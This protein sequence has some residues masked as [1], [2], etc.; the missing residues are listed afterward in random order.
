MLSIVEF[1][2]KHKVPE[3]F[4]SNFYL[5]N[6]LDL[7]N[8]YQP[9]CSEKGI[10]ESQ[11][12]YYHYYNY[13]IKSFF[14]KS[15]ASREYLGQESHVN[16]NIILDIYKNT[17]I[18]FKV[19]YCLSTHNRLKFLKKTLPH[20]ISQLKNDEQIVL[21]DYGSSDGTESFIDNNFRIEISQEKLKFIQVF[22]VKY[23][24]ASIAKNISHYYSEG[25]YLYNIDCDNFI[26]NHRDFLN[27][28]I[29]ISPK[30]FVLH[31]SLQDLI[32]EKLG[33]E[34][35]FGQICMHRD[36][37]LALSGYNESFMP[38]GY[39]DTDILLRSRA[40]N[41]RYVNIPLKTEPVKHTKTIV[42]SSP[43]NFFSWGDCLDYNKKLS[44]Y[45][46]SK[47]S[48]YACNI[49]K[50]LR[51]RINFNEDILI[52]YSNT[53]DFTELFNITKQINPLGENKYD[54]LINHEFD[55]HFDLID[56]YLKN[57]SNELLY[58][59]PETIL[60][61][62]KKLKSNIINYSSKYC[63]IYSEFSLDK[64]YTRSSFTNEK[65]WLSK[66]IASENIIRQKTNGSSTGNSF[67]FFNNNRYFDKVQ[68]IFEFDLIRSEYNLL[69]KKIKLLLLINWPF[70]PDGF[71]GFS[72]C[73][74]NHQPGNK[75]NNFNAKNYTTHF[76]NFEGY[77]D[78]DVWYNKLLDL[79]SK[80]T[81]DIVLSS[82]PIIN[83][84][85]K[86][87]KQNSFRHK[88]AKLLSHT[89]EFPRHDDFNFL[90]KH[91]NID[92][93]CDHMRCWDG[94]ATFFTCKHGTYHLN[95][96]ASWCE[97][98]ENKE[99]ISTDYFNT[100]TPFLNYFN[101]DLC[102]IN[103]DYEK[104]ACGRYYRPFKL[105]QS[106]PF[107]AKNGKIIKVA[108]ENFKKLNFKNK[109]NQVEFLNFQVSVHCNT[110]LN[111]KEKSLVKDILKQ[112]N[113]VFVY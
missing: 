111:T 67:K 89:T 66:F 56:F 32:E 24:H 25:E 84:L 107:L 71:D 4:D 83:L 54:I 105:L 78:Y 72:T 41:F 60:Q 23:F 35:S 48:F 96:A 33:F 108:R 12:L 81:F 77:E 10:T 44:S 109:I 69:N 75:F 70:S 15:L 80:H 98:G 27:E 61:V 3:E 102:E 95:D 20:N 91:G 97:Q 86:Y 64:I 82:G 50:K 42:Y 8:F 57:I 49:K 73:I 1:F 16:K 46:L 88:F 38:I 101:G 43:E 103:N 28:Q 104:C 87:I 40:L 34:G 39:Q 113:V 31:N 36:D 99:L 19:S 47:N 53:K 100:A 52:A 92:D 11:R 112:F 93:F 30:G 79:L 94:G 2:E 26:S 13:G 58:Q 68:N 5:K 9:F 21:V 63:P 62:S 110:I 51:G 74:D 37:F 90:K 45:N 7:S 59:N 65:L 55:S 22:D 14:S 76:V 106:R 18:K 85:T 29:L 17:K 6:N